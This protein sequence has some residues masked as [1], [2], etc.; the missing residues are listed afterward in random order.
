[1]KGAAILHIN[2]LDSLKV[3][4]S[5]VLPSHS[6]LGIY[7]REQKAHIFTDLDMNVSNLFFW[8]S[9]KLETTQMPIDSHTN[10]SIHPVDVYGFPHTSQ[11]HS[12][13]P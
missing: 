6:L 2:L 8:I 11:S 3:T 5:I 12:Q 13:H 7:L 10:L 1:M 9:P 4:H